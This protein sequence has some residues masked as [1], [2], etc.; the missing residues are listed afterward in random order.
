MSDYSIN[1]AEM[2]LRIKELRTRQNKTQEY[3]ASQINI[4]TSY[5]ALIE[6]GKRTPT[7]DVLAQIVKKYNVSIDY[8]VFGTEESR[9]D[10][11]S[12][13]FSR[14]CSK[15]STNDISKALRLAEYY[16]KLKDE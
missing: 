16:L 11:N 15:Y 7:I 8:L 1:L 9:E 2:G 12:H 10:E 13:I 6:N 3:F 4:S 14:L 5:L